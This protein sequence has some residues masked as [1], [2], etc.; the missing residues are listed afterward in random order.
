MKEKVKS[1]FLC[2]AIL[3]Q[4]KSSESIIKLYA[5][6]CNYDASIFFKGITEVGLYSCTSTGY[7]FW[8]PVDIVGD[9]KFYKDISHLWPNYYR[10]NR[11]EHSL[12]LNFLKNKEKLLEIGCGPGHF[13]KSFENLSQDVVGLEFNEDAINR[14]VTKYEIFKKSI[15]EF[16][17]ENLSRF[18]AVYAFQVLEHVIDPYTFLKSAQEALVKG[19]IIIISVPNNK[20]NEFSQQKDAFDLP[21]HHIGHFDRDIFINIA[22]LMSLNVVEIFEEKLVGKLDSLKKKLN[23]ENKK[24]GPNILVVLEKM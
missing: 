18:D 23:L 10:L 16:S 4:K 24:L 1:P 5:E 6:K 2:D 20:Y 19:G 12:A 22:K 13:M 11:W 8:R 14:K 17:E 3:V 15:E 9:S 21:P 7:K